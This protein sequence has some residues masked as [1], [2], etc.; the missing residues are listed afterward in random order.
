MDFHGLTDMEERFA[1]QWVSNSESGEFIKGHRIVIAELGLSPYEG[2][3]VRDSTLFDEP[4]S[5]QR[6]AH[7]ILVRMAFVQEVFSQSEI[8][9]PLLYRPLE[10]L[11]P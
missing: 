4:W 1:T 5:K 10:R 2:K 7:Y 3:V 9:R 6:R 8:E 11:A